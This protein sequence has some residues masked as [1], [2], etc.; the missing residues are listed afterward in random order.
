[1]AS[2]FSSENIAEIEIDSAAVMTFLY[3][4]ALDPSFTTTTTY[5]ISHHQVS[6]SAVYVLL[7]SLMLCDIYNSLVYNVAQPRR[8]S[9]NLL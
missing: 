7:K 4:Q 9:N 2:L 6:L 5:N 8:G 3:H 1:M